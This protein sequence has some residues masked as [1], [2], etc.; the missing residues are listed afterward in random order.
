MTGVS[1]VVVA[2]AIDD[3][4]HTVESLSPPGSFTV[5]EVP[6]F[7]PGSRVLVSPFNALA[8]LR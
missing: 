7:E 2:W 1:P 3:L 6:G 5:E 4:S 8:L